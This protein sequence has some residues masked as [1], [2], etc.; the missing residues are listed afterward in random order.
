MN[1]TLERSCT[2]G[3]VGYHAALAFERAGARI[4]ALAEIE[5]AVHNSAGLSLDQVIEHRQRTGSIRDYPDGNNLTS[6]EALELQC[7]ILVPAALQHQIV[8]ANAARIRAKVIAEAANAPLTTAADAMLRQAGVMIVPDVFLNAGGVTVSYF[9]WLKNLEHVSFERLI[10]R[11]EK[12]V[13]E[14]FAEAL[15]RLT[16]KSL[17]L[18]VRSSLAHGPT[19]PELVRGALENTQCIAYRAVR[20]LYRER[21]L[22]DLRT[23]A[24]VLAIDRVAEVY[25]RSGIFP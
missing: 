11:W 18:S 13:G 5:G 23:A 20:D 8:E 25:E 21:K 9:E 2:L 17:D 24:W 12:T 4:I 15:E 7:D 19:E 14:R 22:P 6:G 10:T 3:N 16:G 1:P